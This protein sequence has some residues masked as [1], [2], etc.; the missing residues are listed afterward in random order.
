[1][2]R[3]FV[4]I[5]FACHLSLANCGSSAARNVTRFEAFGNKE[6]DNKELFINSGMKVNLWEVC[7]DGR[8]RNVDIQAI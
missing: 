5:L 7:S 8:Q 3:E 6:A 1:M 4:F 2:A